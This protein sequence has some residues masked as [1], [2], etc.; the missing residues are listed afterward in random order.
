MRI[1][2]KMSEN[3]FNKKEINFI[4][5]IYKCYFIKIKNT[6]YVEILF[7]LEYCKLT[8][9]ELNCQ[10]FSEKEQKNIT[11]PNFVGKKITLVSNDSLTRVLKCSE[12][13]LN[14]KSSSKKFINIY[15]EFENILEFYSKNLCN[16]Y[17]LEDDLPGNLYITVGSI[18]FLDTLILRVTPLDIKEKTGCTLQYRP[19][20][21][22]G[23]KI[24]KTNGLKR[25]S[26]LPII[27]IHPVN[28]KMKLFVYVFDLYTKL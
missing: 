20:E 12:L 27:T 22:E 3:I 14:I 5:E 10:T 28:L 21:K 26:I 2:L 18:K 16:E 8:E 23:W 15:T 17:Y 11:N 4:Q 25:K 1:V 24:V 7:L 6:N 9:K 13:L 19:D